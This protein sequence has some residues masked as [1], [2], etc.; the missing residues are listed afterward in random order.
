M[1]TLLQ[2]LS[3]AAHPQTHRIF[4][5]PSLQTPPCPVGFPPSAGHTEGIFPELQKH[6]SVRTR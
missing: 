6:C 2:S 5:L 4:F 1:A 3:L